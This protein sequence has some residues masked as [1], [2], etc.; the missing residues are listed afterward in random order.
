[1]ASQPTILLRS[2]VGTLNRPA[3]HRATASSIVRST[4][5]SVRASTSA[6]VWRNTCGLRVQRRVGGELPVAPHRRL[7][8]PRHCRDL[9]GPYPYCGEVSVRDMD[10]ADVQSV[11]VLRGTDVT[12][13]SVAH[14]HAA[15]GV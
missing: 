7:T 8:E 9:I 2:T 13:A 3:V 14:G 4:M 11:D 6:V 15:I 10:A 1:V 5:S 12:V